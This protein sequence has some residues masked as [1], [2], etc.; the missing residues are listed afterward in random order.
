MADVT[1]EGG[2]RTLR[3]KKAD[4]GYDMFGRSV[5]LQPDLASSHARGIV[6]D[7]HRLP[8][9][10]DVERL[11]TRLAEAVAGV[12]HA[13]ERHVRTDAVGRTIDRYEPD[14]LPRDELLDPVAVGRLD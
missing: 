4:G 5:R 12:L 6:V 3:S 9:A 1:F 10:V 13:A 2:R 7:D 8:L 11:G 14:E